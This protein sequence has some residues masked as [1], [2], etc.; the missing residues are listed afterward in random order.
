MK[1]GKLIVKQQYIEPIVVFVITGR[2]LARI[3]KKENMGY[4]E[5]PSHHILKRSP[6]QGDFKDDV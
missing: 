2:V 6:Q 1:T 3:R 5:G 4:G